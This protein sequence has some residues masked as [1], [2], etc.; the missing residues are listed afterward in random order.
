[1]QVLGPS[2]ISWLRLD[3]AVEAGRRFAL[4]Q[5]FNADPSVDVMLLTTAVCSLPLLL[6]TPA[7][8]LAFSSLLLG[9]A[10][11]HSCIRRSAT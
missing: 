6:A 2:G 3:G 10:C 5:Q 1:M 8:T 9:G 7:Y 4:V 11:I